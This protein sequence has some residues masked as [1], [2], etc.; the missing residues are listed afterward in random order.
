MFLFFSGKL[1]THANLFQSLL[2]PFLVFCYGFMKARE[3]ERRKRKEERSADLTLTNS[4]NSERC[5][6]TE[7]TAVRENRAVSVLF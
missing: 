4:F 1:S 6:G 3:D 5:L 2:P 7:T